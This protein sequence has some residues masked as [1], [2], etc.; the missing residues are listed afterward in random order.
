LEAVRSDRAL[1]P[2][3]IE[4]GLRWEPPLLTIMRT[5]TRDTEVEGVRLP[6]DA[7]VIANLGSANHDESRWAAPERFDIFRPPQQHLAFAFGAHLCL[8]MHLARMETAVLVN[9]V[10]D[11]L[12]GIRFDPDLDPPAITGMTFRAPAAIPV[13]WDT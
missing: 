11:R 7:V 5:V 2:Q 10:L 12:P 4:E 13:V 1:V 9:A 3:A 6:K 8:G